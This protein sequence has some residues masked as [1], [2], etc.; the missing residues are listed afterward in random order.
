MKDPEIVAQFQTWS[1]R[2]AVD[3]RRL[4]RPADSAAQAAEKNRAALDVP[5]PT[6]RHSKNGFRNAVR[7]LLGLSGRCASPPESAASD[8]WLNPHPKIVARFRAE[9]A[10][11]IDLILCGAL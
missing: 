9:K 4:E 6:L 10:I 3:D 5:P 7:T 11:L 1:I 2:L 8:V